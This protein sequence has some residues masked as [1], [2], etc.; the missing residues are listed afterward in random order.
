MDVGWVRGAD[1][2]NA[3][4][5]H[6][7]P[8]F[9]WGRHCRIARIQ[10][11]Q[12]SLYG[13]AFLRALWYRYSCPIMHCTFDGAIREAPTLSLTLAVGHREGSFVVTPDAR[14]DDGL[15]DYLHVGPLARWEVLRFMPKLASGGRLPNDHPAIWLGRCREVQLRSATPLTIHLDGE[16]FCRSEDNL[17]S[18]EVRLLPAAL[19]VRTVQ[20]TELK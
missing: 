17:H 14:L 15:F 5:Q 11:L 13:L 19:R 3:I 16:F 2:A 6:P 18:I 1:G 4:C 10:W 7:R 9:Q 12:G 20:S 8:R